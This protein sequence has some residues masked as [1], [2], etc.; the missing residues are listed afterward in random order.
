MK[1]TEQSIQ[2]FYPEPEFAPLQNKRRT[3]LVWDAEGP[4][5][6]GDWTTVLWSS[7]GKA[8]DPSIISIPTL[9]EEQADALRAR[10]LAWVYELGETLINGKRVVDHLELRPGFSYWWMTSLAHKPNFYESPHINVVVKC[11]AFE[12]LYNEKYP[13]SKIKLI[14]SNEKI[15]TLI[16]QYCFNINVEF[17]CEDIEPVISNKSIN[18]SIK[19]LFPSRLKAVLLLLLSSIRR[20][21]NFSSNDKQWKQ[22]I[23]STVCIFDI[24]VHLR[25]QSFSEGKFFSDYWTKLTLL[26]ERLNMPT[27]WIHKYYKYQD[28]KSIK[29]ARA[30]VQSFNKSN[31]YNN[32]H[33]LIDSQLDTRA[34]LT[35]ISLYLRLTLISLR[36]STVNKIFKP[37]KSHFNFWPL[38]EKNWHD[39]LIGTAAMSNCI[40][41]SIYDSALR[42]MPR[43]SMGFYIQENQPWEMALIYAWRD[44]GHGRLIGVPHATV[45]FWDLRYFY[46]SRTY[47][48]G[49]RNDLPM[50]DMVAVNGPVSLK[51][52]LDGGYPESQLFE[53]EALRYLHLRDESLSLKKV[54]TVGSPLRVLICGDN[55]PGSNERLMQLLQIAAR[56]LPL[57]TRYIFKPH[58]VRPLE[59]SKYRSLNLIVTDET[60]AKLLNECD[61]VITGNITS[62]AVDAYC[63]GLIVGSML[64][65]ESPNASPLRGLRGVKYFTNAA[66]LIDII[67]SSRVCEPLA[68]DPY[69]HMDE[70]LPRWINLLKTLTEK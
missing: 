16:Q 18:L 27:T 11:F 60:L 12:Y 33:A 66:E 36:L 31:N 52:Y 10:Y 39:S 25:S 15:K 40:S 7:F 61:V 48:S 68:T 53:V 70:T 57:D 23:N 64:D 47:R 35:S 42:K 41:L 19:K 1:N 43:Q 20:Y 55:I 46:D 9:V 4:P 6:V 69:F 21:W 13:P 5:P 51:A 63:R 49:S 26:L 22:N 45:R 58:K 3:L 38:F 59:V 24:F 32:F 67:S 17:C 50:P 28:V 34:T 30:L 37:A 29:H 2:N 65:G 56:E 54:V 8:N 62:A 14:T 44:A